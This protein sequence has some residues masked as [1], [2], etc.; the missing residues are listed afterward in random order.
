MNPMTD[1]EYLNSG[2]NK[3]PYCHSEN[4]ESENQP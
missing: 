1:Q 3:C 2:G 4:I